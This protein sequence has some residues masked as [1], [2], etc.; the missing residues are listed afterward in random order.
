[1]RKKRSSKQEALI[2]NFPQQRGDYERQKSPIIHKHLNSKK[3]LLTLI[4][5]YVKHADDICEGHV[6]EN[7]EKNSIDVHHSLLVDIDLQ[8]DQTDH[9]P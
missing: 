3:Q 2:I 5:T 4:S 9:Q 6:N 8:I 1:M 7:E